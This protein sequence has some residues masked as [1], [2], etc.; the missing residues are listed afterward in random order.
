MLNVCKKNLRNNEKN[1]FI[2]RQPE[3]D[4]LGAYIY[5][6]SK[7][8]ENYI[9]ARDD[10]MQ[11]ES[12]NLK[13]LFRNG[14]AKKMRRLDYQN[15][16]VFYH[17][18]IFLLK[19]SKPFMRKIFRNNYYFLSNNLHKFLDQIVS[20]NFLNKFKNV[21]IFL[22][23]GNAKRPKDLLLKR[24][25]M[26]NSKIIALPHSYH[27]VKNRKRDLKAF[28]SYNNCW[29]NEIYTYGELPQISLKSFCQNI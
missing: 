24:L 23:H 13:A 9:F 26:G 7:N 14:Y 1:F 18:I 11:L 19:I 6:N 29:A 22:D 16:S 12:I 17:P 25:I 20:E 5:F 8:Y 28:S 10:D 2:S 4:H 21:D 3:V 15:Y 27:Y